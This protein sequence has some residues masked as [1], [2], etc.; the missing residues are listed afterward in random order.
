MEEEKLI[1]SN[2]K[3]FLNEYRNSFFFN[4]F[5]SFF[6]GESLATRYDDKLAHLLMPSLANYEFERITG[7]N[8]GIE[9]F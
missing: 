5:Y 4:S 6:K 8:F 2:L 3:F 1:E 9:E 7:K